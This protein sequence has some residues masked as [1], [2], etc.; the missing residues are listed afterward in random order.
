MLVFEEDG[1]CNSVPIFCILL[2]LSKF[3]CGV[4]LYPLRYPLVA[5]HLQRPRFIE[6]MHPRRYRFPTREIRREFFSLPLPIRPSQLI[7]NVHS[8]KV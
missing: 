2:G 6:K 3:L 7:G 8:K 1:T 4:S 5:L